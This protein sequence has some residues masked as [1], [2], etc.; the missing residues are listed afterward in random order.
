MTLRCYYRAVFTALLAIALPHSLRAQ[1]DTSW[2]GA[3]ADAKALRQA[4]SLRRSILALASFAGFADAPCAPGDIRTF[5][6]DTT[7]RAVELL[8]RLELLVLSYGAYGSLDSDAGRAL[9]RAVTRLETGGPGPRW[10]VL[11]GASPRAFNAELPTS[12]HNSSTNQCELTPGKAPFGL[13]LPVTPGFVPPLDSGA[14]GVIVEQGRDGV[15]RVRDFFFSSARGRDSGAVLRHTR[16]NAYSMWG[17]YAIV[18]VQRDA[19]YRG[20]IPVQGESSG[21][22]YAF[23]RAEG[24]WRLLALIRN[25]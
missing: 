7:G 20:V 4:D 18:A 25:W 10:D 19:E 1:S 23:H 11:S 2:S 8:R 22:V 13:V 9:M 16:V 17:D 15:K 12:M 5:D 24:E 3:A 14:V 21:A 6:R